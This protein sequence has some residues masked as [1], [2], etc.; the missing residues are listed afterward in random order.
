VYSASH[1]LRAPLRAIDGFSQMI[2]EDA[3][4]RLDADDLEHLQRVR[5]AARRMALLIDHLIALSRTSRQDLLLAPT[6]LSAMAESVL[7]DLREAEPARRVSA[8]VEPG[9]VV[10]ADAALLHVILT[11]L[12]AN[13]WKFT[14]H[15]GSARIEVGARAGQDE[16]AFFVKDDGAGF[17]PAKAEHLFGAFQRFHAAEE[18]EGDGIGLAT[19]QRLVAKHGGRVWAEAEVDKGATFFFTL[20]APASRD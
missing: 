18:F 15:N 4:D 7:A 14:S 16:R 8:V 6:D 10:H 12:L 2:V 3:A 9:I 11:N 20:P 19:V 5:A 1:D 17:D 13:A